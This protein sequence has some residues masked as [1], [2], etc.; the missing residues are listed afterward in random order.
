MHLK[1]LA[2]W[3]RRVQKQRGA[4]RDIAKHNARLVMQQQQVLLHLSIKAQSGC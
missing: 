1:V 3:V 2:E 4:L